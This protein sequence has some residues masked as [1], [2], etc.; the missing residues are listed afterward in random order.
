MPLYLSLK[1]QDP[2]CKFLRF[3]VSD[4]RNL[5]PI[6]CFRQ[7]IILQITKIFVMVGVARSGFHH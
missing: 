3:I 5:L 2:F 4:C 1:S 7:D 6:P